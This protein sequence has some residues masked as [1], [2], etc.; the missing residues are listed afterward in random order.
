MAEHSSATGA[1][2]VALLARPGKAAD[3]LTDALRQAGADLV[4]V[5]DPNTLDLQTLADAQLQAV[6]VALEPGVEQAIDR[7]DPVLSAPELTVIFDEADLAA[8][9][10]GWDAARWVRHLSAKLN[11]H[12]RVLP[13]GGEAETEEWHPSPGQLPQPSADFV[14]LNFDTFAEE[15]AVHADDVP[16]DGMNTDVAFAGARAD[17]FSFDAPVQEASQSMEMP[18]VPASSSLFGSSPLDSKLIESQLLESQPSELPSESMAWSHHPVS[19]TD[20]IADASSL[21]ET[22]FDESANDVSMIEHAFDTATIEQ[23]PAFKESDVEQLNVEQLHVEDWSVEEFRTEEFRVEEFRTESMLPEQAASSLSADEAP[24]VQPMRFD[25]DAFFLE[26][27][28]ADAGKPV[29]IETDFTFDAIADF[30]ESV[31][32]AQPVRAA[33]FDLEVTD[34]SFEAYAPETSAPMQTLEEEPA[35]F[36]LDTFGELSLAS[37]D[38]PA[39]ATVPRAPGF[40][41]DLSA[42]ESRISSLSLVD[43]E[44]AQ[45][46]ADAMSEAVSDAGDGA[47]S[48]MASPPDASSAMPPPLPASASLAVVPPVDTAQMMHSTERGI[49][50]IEAGL[51]GPDPVRQVLAGLPPA[52]PKPVLVRLHLQGGRYDRLVTQMERA[53]SLPVMLAEVGAQVRPGCIYFL[54]E[55]VGLQALSDGMQFIAHPSPSATIFAALPVEDSAVL[56]LSG[57]DSSLIDDAMQAANGGALVAAQSPE[58]CYDGAACGHLSAR[59]APSGLPTDLARRLL[60]RW[61]SL[62]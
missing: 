17:R 62:I 26:E 4:L 2:R 39:A 15:A 14:D 57:S 48:A 53:A 8:H 61:P 36:A 18:V 41:R 5:A 10:A 27:L 43:L 21:S 7:L 44:P 29:S 34:L 50:L 12:Q 22:S 56:F 24:A 60:L 46:S 40:T 28:S 54:P 19:V 3:N 32:S 37:D 9:R 16:A 30:E 13:P 1:Q 47:E 59:G 55:G 38:T 33:E 52:F 6:L 25:D 49:V 42:L 58:D 45:A 51:G 35:G 23:S 20:T 31:P 11:H